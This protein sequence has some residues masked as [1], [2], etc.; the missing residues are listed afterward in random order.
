MSNPSTDSGSGSSRLDELAEEFARRYQQGERPALSEYTARYPELADEI[1]ELF[2]ALALLQQVRPEPGDATGPYQPGQDATGDTGLERLGEYRI[3]R[4]VG[5]GG[6]GIVYEAEQESLGRHVALK[7]LPAQALLDATRLQRFQQE[8]KAAARLHHTNIVPVYGVGEQGGLHYYVMQFIQGLAL[9]EVLAEL[10]KLRQARQAPATAAQDTPQGGRVGEVSAADVAQALLTGAFAPHEAA[11]RGRQPPEETE[12]PPKEDASVRLPGS[13]GHSSLSESGRQYWESVA[14]VG[15]QVAEALAY[16]HGQGTLHRDVKPSNLLLDTRDTVWVTDFGLAKAQ[17]GEDLTNTGDIVGTLRY[18]APERFAGQ[19]DARSDV[20]ALGLTLY[21]L[22]TLRSAFEAA[23]RHR[24]IDQVKNEEPP[25]PRKLDPGVPRD[26]ETVVLKAMAKEPGHRYQAA[27]ELAEDLRRFVE[28]KPIRARPVSAAERLWRWCR[29]NPAVA[30]LTGAVGLLLVVLGRAGREADRQAN[31]GR[32]ADRQANAAREHAGKEEQARHQAEARL[33]RLFVS[34]GTRALEQGDLLDSLPWFTEALKIEKGDPARAELHRIRLRSLLQRCPRLRAFPHEGITSAQFSPDGRRV[35]TIGIHTGK[36]YEEE[37]EVRIWDA[38]T[39]QPVIP[40][41]RYAF[42]VELVHS[43][44]GRHFLAF[45]DGQHALTTGTPEREVRVWDTATGQARLLHVQP[46]GAVFHASFSPDSR[47]I[48]IVS[49]RKEKQGKDSKNRGWDSLGRP[50]FALKTEM[51]VWDAGTGQALTSPMRHNSYVNCASFSPDGG[52]IAT[53]SGAGEIAGAL[54]LWDA[55]TGQLLRGPLR[56]SGM[57]LFAATF[58]RDGQRVLVMSTGGA[59][60]WD[61]GTGQLIIG[62]LEHPQPF[63][64]YRLAKFSPDGRRIVTADHSETRVWDAATGK[65]LAQLPGN[66]PGAWFSPDSRRVLTADRVGSLQ[67]LKLQFRHV[68]EERPNDVRVWD[69]E[70]GQ[71]VSLPF[72]HNLLLQDASFSPDGHHVLTVSGVDRGSGDERPGELRVWD[73]VSGR[74][75]TPALKHGGEVFSACFSPDGSRVLTAGKD[76]LARVWDLSA[77]IL[78]PPRPGAGKDLFS[79][80]PAD[81]VLGDGFFLVDGIHFSPAHF[82]PD[83]RRVLLGGRGPSLDQ[84]AVRVWDTTTGK[85]V[86]PPMQLGGNA[87]LLDWSFSP[88]GRHLVTICICNRKEEVFDEARVWDAVSGAAVCPPIKYAGFGLCFSFNGR[89]LVLGCFNGK[90][91]TW[92]ARTGKPVR[93]APWQDDSIE[94]VTHS[95]DGSRLL[96]AANTDTGGS[97][98]RVRNT[99]TGQPVT[100][101]IT[102]D[103]HMEY[104]LFSPD[105]RRILTLND[106]SSATGRGEVRV[107]DAATGQPL[108]PYLT[109]YLKHRHPL[110]YACFSRDGRR[111]LTVTPDG[112]AQVWDAATGEPVTLPLV[113]RGS[114]SAAVF[115]ADN[116]HVLTLTEDARIQVWDLSPDRRPL[117]DLVLLAN[118]LSSRRVDDSGTSVLFRAGK[119]DWQNLQSKYPSLFAVPARPGIAWHRH[120]AEACEN[121]RDWFAAVF[122][123]NRLIAEQ[124]GSAALYR[125]RGLARARQGEFGPSRVDFARACEVGREA[126]RK[127]DYTRLSGYLA[128]VCLATGDAASARK[129]CAEMLKD[130]GQSQ[131]KELVQHVAWTCVLVPNAVPDFQPVLRLAEK[132]GDP[133]VLGAAQYR[134]GQCVMALQTLKAATSESKDEGRIENWLFQA[135]AH[136]RLGHKEARDALAE[137]VRR[138]EQ[139]ATG[140]GLS[141]DRRLELQLLRREAE[142]LIHGKATA[143][144]K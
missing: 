133:L 103:G 128:R 120:Q 132:S 3:L 122:H 41:I 43:P 116:R 51:R 16:A 50:A 56:R 83:G 143:P 13:S 98:M 111:V 136:H 131:N 82:S 12:S 11:S 81:K 74:P 126:M 30:G 77:L 79:F 142:A 102:Q 45:E 134:C 89:F 110:S 29:R 129:V 54:Y 107:W 84:L 72:Q 59:L 123:L 52:W 86:T 44:D 137:A 46:A 112:G 4:E 109:P 55:A 5:R 139:A 17:D 113:P 19:S 75:V 119:A 34:S 88:D 42:R 57:D 58:S 125:R 2:P 65:L 63:A 97:R 27:A 24:L 47:R 127:D 22:L 144:R 18:M 14:R 15:I 38:D 114:L 96:T 124:P 39:G 105:G 93:P 80:L 73:A 49:S 95:P 31:A 8:A 67:M 76:G 99:V 37:S 106:R 85:P 33:A 69:A 32:E 64:D 66:C 115:A 68:P 104:A 10:K 118:L 20:Y 94:F 21:E 26:L 60:V 71:P 62:P 92:D 140:G 117:A 36:G 101:P 25:R 61:A 48:L 7:V 100:P 23:D 9:D 108:T 130:F 135:M 1:R 78:Q 141:W 121:A 35:V 138:I 40:P 28:D 87:R 70:T 53:V 91:R 6:M 90:V